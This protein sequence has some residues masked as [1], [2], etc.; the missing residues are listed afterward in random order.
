MSCRNDAEFSDNSSAGQKMEKKQ[1]REFASCVLLLCLNRV[2]SVYIFYPSKCAGESPV[3]FFVAA[4]PIAQ[5]KSG[6][7]VDLC[8]HA[9]RRIV[10][11]VRVASLPRELHWRQP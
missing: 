7:G 2:N 4:P 10:G 8:A 11:D 3:I 6:P 1:N 5:H 9:F